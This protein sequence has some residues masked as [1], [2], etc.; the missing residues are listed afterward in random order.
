MKGLSRDWVI[1]E[2][3]NL[4][5][6][7]TEGKDTGIIDILLTGNIDEYHINDLSRKIES[8]K[9]IPS[10]IDVLSDFF[11]L[12]HEM[13]SLFHWGQ[14]IRCLSLIARPLRLMSAIMAK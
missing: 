14:K 1:L 2:R 8:R 4:I 3:T 12:P 11:S 13:H 10:G 9:P 6:D 5:N 7:Y